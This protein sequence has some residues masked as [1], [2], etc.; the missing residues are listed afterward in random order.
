MKPLLSCTN[1][2]S[3]QRIVTMQTALHKAK[4]KDRSL[5]DANTRFIVSGGTYL[6]RVGFGQGLVLPATANSL[7][8]GIGRAPPGRGGHQPTTLTI[9]FDVGI[10][11]RA[12]H[13]RN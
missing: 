2:R 6:H 5:N 7:H 11:P 8:M 10:L 12:A 4:K 9:A 3:G 1:W 13:G